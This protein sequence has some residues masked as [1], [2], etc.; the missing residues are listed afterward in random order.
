M[1]NKNYDEVISLKNLVLAWKKARIGKTKKSYVVEFEKNL[2]MNLKKLH[3]ELKEETYF[4]KP[5]KEFIVRDPKTRRISKSH[6]RDRIVHH[7]L[8]NVIE[9]IFDKI[10]IYDNC[11]NIKNK[12]SLFALKRFDFFKRKVT[13]NLSIE[14]YCLKADIKH[15]FREINLDILVE[16]IEKRVKDKRTLS[17]IK[18]ILENKTEFER[19][20]ER[21]PEL[22]IKECR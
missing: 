11:A 17:L 21:R 8:C 7:A 10:F 14:G 15:Y 22:I 6:F 16:I 20:R 18:K 19:E 3:E 13:N 1:E 5:L 9:P 4:P 2:G 12:G